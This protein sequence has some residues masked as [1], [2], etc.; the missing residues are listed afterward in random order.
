MAQNPNLLHHQ[1]H[2]PLWIRGQKAPLQWLSSEFP[3]LEPGGVLNFGQDHEVEQSLT[4]GLVSFEPME[5]RGQ[6]VFWVVWEEVL[7]EQQTMSITVV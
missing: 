7:Q 5:R 1:A 6:D 2:Q 3:Q 4:Q